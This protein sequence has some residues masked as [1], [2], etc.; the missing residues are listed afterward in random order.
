MK[1]F[2]LLPWTDWCALGF[3]ILVWNVYALFTKHWSDGQTS[4][5]ALTNRYRHLWMLQTTERESA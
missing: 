3:F 2:Q 4:I 5:L 1:I